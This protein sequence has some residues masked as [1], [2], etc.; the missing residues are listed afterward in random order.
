MQDCNYIFEEAK[1]LKMHFKDFHNILED[2]ALTYNFD[3]WY[4]VQL[5][6][7]KFRHL[8]E[9]RKKSFPHIASLI[10]GRIRSNA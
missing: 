2:V 7:N 5:F 4:L 10:F 9:H 1:E 8:T 3:H 6:D